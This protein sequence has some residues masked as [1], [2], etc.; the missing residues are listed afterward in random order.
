MDFFFIYFLKESFLI[1][2]DMKLFS[3]MNKKIGELPL[4][5]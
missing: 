1:F 3:L 4:K 2:L 5:V